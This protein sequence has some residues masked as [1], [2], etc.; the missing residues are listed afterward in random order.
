V[1]VSGGGP[2]AVVTGRLAVA[3]DYTLEAIDE[4]GAPEPEVVV[5]PAVLA[6]RGRREQLRLDAARPCRPR[7]PGHRSANAKSIEYPLDH[8]RLTGAVQRSR[9]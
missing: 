2:T 7:R 8:L 5:V 4:D 1:D 6:P 9:R 3:A